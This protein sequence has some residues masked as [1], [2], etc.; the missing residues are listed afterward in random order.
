[1]AYNPLISGTTKRFI[2]LSKIIT[3]SNLPHLKFGVTFW[4]KFHSATILPCYEPWIYLLRG[5]T[6][7]IGRSTKLIKENDFYPSFHILI[8]IAKSSFISCPEYIACFFKA[9]LLKKP[10]FFN[11]PQVVR[12]ASLC[13]EKNSSQQHTFDAANKQFII[14]Q[15]SNNNKDGRLQC[16]VAQNIPTTSIEKTI[17]RMKNLKNRN[18]MC[19]SLLLRVFNKRLLN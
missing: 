8:E 9:T 6:I 3:H 4:S 17:S 7:K 12:L 2:R 16:E 10:N 14:Q 18:L 13:I 15:R 1:M 5:K 11:S 19:H